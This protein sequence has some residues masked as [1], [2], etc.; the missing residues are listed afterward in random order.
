VAITAAV[1]A[2]VRKSLITALAQVGVALATISTTKS[3]FNPNVLAQ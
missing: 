1:V 2:V 3:R